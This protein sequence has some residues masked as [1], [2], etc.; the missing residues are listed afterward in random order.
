MRVEVGYQR[1]PVCVCVCVARAR[2]CV[3]HRPDSILY[4]DTGLTEIFA[5]QDFFHSPQLPFQLRRSA[6]RCIFWFLKTTDSLS[7]A[8]PHAHHAL[9]VSTNH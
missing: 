7:D 9:P 3:V 1:A 5:G 6:Q 8:L 2:S 4:T